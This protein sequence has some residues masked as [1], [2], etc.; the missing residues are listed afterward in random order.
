MRGLQL[1]K[2][3]LKYSRGSGNNKASPI[4][5]FFAKRE[6][7][8]DIAIKKKFGSRMGSHG[9]DFKIGKKF[10][11]GMSSKSISPSV[12]EFDS[13]MSGVAGKSSKKSMFRKKM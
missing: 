7:K 11:S 9:K 1:G 6:S 13:M 10:S 12:D 8:S 5:N 4:K 3:L 2:S